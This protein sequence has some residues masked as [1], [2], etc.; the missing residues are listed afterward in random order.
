MH[1]QFRSTTWRIMSY[2]MLFILVLSPFTN[3]TAQANT[4]EQ[5]ADPNG[6]AAPGDHLV[7]E[8]SLNPDSPNIL[9]T[10]DQ[11]NLSFQYV[12]NEKSGVRIF[13]RPFTNGALTLNYGAHGSIL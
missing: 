10:N 13:A 2:L 12:T 8:I 3:F 6:P 4:H 5:E 9:R 7:T 1:T 11:V